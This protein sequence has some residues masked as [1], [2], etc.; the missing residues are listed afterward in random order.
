[1]GLAQ[2]IS[3]IVFGVPAHMMHPQT[4]VKHPITWL[5][6][7]S[8]VNGTISF[9]PNFAYNLCIKRVKDAALSEINLGSWRL[10]A[11]G[12]EP[13][14]FQTMQEFAKKFS[15][16]GFNSSAL[17][18]CYG[19]AESTVGVTFNPANSGVRHFD[20]D[21]NTLAAENRAVAP[22][23]PDSQSI[24]LVCCGSALPDH[25]IAIAD[26]DGNRLANAQVG[27][28]LIKGDSLMQGYYNDE[29][30]TAET[31]QDGWLHTGDLGFLINDELYIC[32]R[33]KELVIVAGRNYYPAD[34]EWAAAQVEGIR[35]G[36]VIAFSIGEFT[37]S[38]EQL[39][40][41]A[42]SKLDK[43]AYQQQAKEVS[44]NIL[45]ALGIKAAEVILL[46][47]QSLPKTTSGKLQRSLAKKN[48][49]KRTT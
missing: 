47:P 16:A 29:K 37:N 3:P 35:A 4:F 26:E 20:V 1:M 12:A 36:N 32:G 49:L 25:E 40:V 27:E 28:I 14:N 34:I 45:T 31:L 39:V 17:S 10:A 5:K 30:A 11:C 46:P 15:S 19:L 2:V 42:E 21:L 48:Y 9:A 43:G 38:E 44:A 8:R 24:R 23:V 41:L 33:K 22:N 13:V 6:V 18:P 7:M